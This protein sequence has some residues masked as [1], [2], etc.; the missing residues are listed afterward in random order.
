MIAPKQAA[1]QVIYLIACFGVVILSFN[2]EI[3]P[4]RF[5]TILGEVLYIHFVIEVRIICLLH[6]NSTV[7]FF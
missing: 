2:E 3:L 7:W 6:T 4:F 1:K 5:I